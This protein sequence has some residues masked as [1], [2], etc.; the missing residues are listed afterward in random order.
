MATIRTATSS[1]TA[2]PALRDVRLYSAAVRTTA[3][4]LISVS[5]ASLP[6]MLV[7]IVLATDPPVTPPILARWF[8][9]FAILPYLLAR[10]LR[11]AAAAAIEPGPSELTV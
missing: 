11:R 2:A 5:A 8:A 7:M 1:A 6:A 9:L 10:L 3:V 4:L